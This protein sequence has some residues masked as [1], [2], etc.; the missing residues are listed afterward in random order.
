MALCPSGTPDVANLGA[1]AIPVCGIAGVL[2]ADA[3]AAIDRSMLQRMADRLRHRGPDGSGLKIGRGYGLAHRR[4]SIID[5]A[6]GQQPMSDG[7]SLVVT[8][9]GEIYNHLELRSELEAK[10]Y[11]FATECDTE[12]LLH[13][14]REWGES[15]P[16]RLRGMFAFVVIDESDR[17]CFA[18]RDR[19]GKKPFYYSECDGDLVFASELKAL[20]EHPRVERRIDAQALEQFLCLRYVPEPNTIFAGIHKLPPGCKMTWRAGKLAIDRYWRLSFANPVAE[21]AE[22]LAEE[23]RERLDDAVRVRL[24][25]EVPLGAF[26]S[27]GIDS[28]AIVESMSRVGAS[29][30]ITCSVGF[31]DPRFD[32]RAEARQ[33]ARAVGATLFEEVVRVED[34]LDMEWFGETFDEPFADI[35]AIPSYHV[36]KMARRH[37]TVALSGDGGDENYAGYRRYR[38]DSLENRVRKVLPGI[39][40][41]GLGAIY[42]KVDFLPRFLRFKR[43]LQDL[44][45]AP[46]RAYARSVSAVLPE[47]LTGILRSYSGADPLAPVIRAYE[48]SDGQDSLSRC[49]AA[50]FATWLPGD[51][52]HKVDRASMAVSLE[53]RCPLLDH[54]LVEA[55]ARIPAHLKLLGG[56]TK[57]LLR[58]AMR[59]RLSQAALTR[60]KRGFTVPLQSWIAGSLGDRMALAF[61]H[62]LL[63]EYLDGTALQR[64]LGQHR[65]GLRDHSSLLWASLVLQGFL[66]RWAS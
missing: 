24:I 9:N 45:C 14:Y 63:N 16:G 3:D 56:Q 11:R 35:S 65:A 66:R 46:A 55:A 32:E 4:L 44:G 8:F 58:L 6:G 48:E 7:G 29:K 40:W 52:L 49:L 30:A 19:I 5:I 60:P 17:S 36:S 23:I 41:R 37:V 54:H 31:D 57:G 18:A 39:L 25:G 10:G 42:P 28:Y 51:I 50:D 62:E 1:L 13:G 34:M 22:D 64:M 26:L 59:N 47:Q 27:G 21:T 38:F 43:T 20:L 53:V 15:L 33:A 12:V 2:T 61:D